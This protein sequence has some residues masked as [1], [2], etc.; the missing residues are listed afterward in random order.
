MSSAIIQCGD[1]FENQL[2][3]LPLA[4]HLKA[5]GIKPIV[6]LYSSKSSRLFNFNKVATVYL[7]AYR[8]SARQELLAF[9]YDYEKIFRIE[10]A[11][12][13]PRF[14]TTAKVKR[15]KQKIDRD[16]TALSSILEDF[17]PQY[18]FIWNGFT[19]N[20]ANLLRV[21]CGLSSHYQTWYMERSFFNNSLFIDP[22]GVNAAASVA[23]Y[24]DD[25]YQDKR[26][27]EEF[28]RGKEALSSELTRDN[29]P[30]EE[31]YVFLPLQVQTD[32]NN[33]L[34]SPYVKKM[35]ALVV[36]VA[37][38]IEHVN[39][40]LGLDIKVVVREHPE[41]ISK[42]LNLPLHS[43]VHY[44]NDGTIKNWCFHAEAV[45]NINSTVGMEAIFTD[46]AVFSFG[47]SL[48][49]H[50]RI[51]T[52]VNP[53]NVQERLLSYFKS[54]DKARKDEN[55]DNFFRF[56]YFYNTCNLNNFPASVSEKMGI[57]QAFVALKTSQDDV[58]KD[59][60]RGKDRVS[61]GCYLSYKTRLNLTYRKNEISPSPEL[62]RH[63]L[64]T[65]YLFSGEVNFTLLSNTDHLENYD[66]I[67]RDHYHVGLNIEHDKVMDEYLSLMSN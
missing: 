57:D 58:V 30:F 38:A 18:F 52:M 32:T 50:D 16:Y 8:L 45:V 17:D 11:R 22:K 6:M 49:S 39:Q 13:Y 48:Y 29:R 33:I 5:N 42:S 47:Q 59:F 20:V 28:Y 3:I 25:S 37:D 62:Y 63:I 43:L 54:S 21:I 44:R 26:I 35:R 36:A 51:Q 46:K 41:E 15:E 19:G 56:L 65:R 53:S 14:N 64:E 7:D 24:F 27:P 66:F 34:Y 31:P 1:H 10:R 9:P 4:L 23:K 61:V 12:A 60:L 67:V 55:A 2:R 40:K